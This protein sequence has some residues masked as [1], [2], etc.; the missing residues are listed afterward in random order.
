MGGSRDVAG[1]IRQ[2]MEA[3][4][5][6][7]MTD[8]RTFVHRAGLSMPQLSL[9]MRLYYGGGCGVHDLGEGFGVSSAAV[10]RMVD[11]L[12]QAGLVDR[13]EDPDDRRVRHVQLSA[14]GRALIDNG[15]RE[16]YRWVDDLV[17]ELPAGQRATVL[18]FLPSLIEAEK[19]LPEA[20]RPRGKRR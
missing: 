16:R 5:M 11:R 14:K 7:S 3:A 17:E 6:R 2:W 15:I 13:G 19:R 1:V 10:S 9:L 8:W 4:A 12:V 18:R 20:I